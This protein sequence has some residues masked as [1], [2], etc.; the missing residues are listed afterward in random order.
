MHRID[1]PTAVPTLPAPR[2]AGTPGYFTGGSPGSGGFAATIVRYEFMN[3]LQEEISHVI[4]QAGLALNKTNNGQLLQALQ[5]MF[6][7]PLSANTTFYVDPAG[8]DANNGLTPGSA[9]RTP[10]AAINTIQTRYNLAGFSVTIQLAAGTCQ[11]PIQIGGTFVGAVDQ[12]TV[13]L[14][15]NVASPGTVIINAP[16][17]GYGLSLIQYGS[18]VISGVTFTAGSGGN[19]IAVGQ[20]CLISFGPGLVFGACPTGTHIY[21]RNGGAGFLDHELYNFRVS[22]R[23]SLIRHNRVGTA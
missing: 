21:I 5:S 12:A 15:G 2:P 19:C 9:F 20:N 17:S 22:G 16:A 4:E 3:A 14:L 7:T 18:I 23:A 11:G 1:D 8:N 10:Q 6:R 13:T